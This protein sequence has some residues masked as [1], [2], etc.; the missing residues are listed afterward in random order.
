[1]KTL[2]KLFPAL[3]LLAALPANAGA[4]DY[5]PPAEPVV[6]PPT[7]APFSWTGPYIGVHA[8][9]AFLR[10]VTEYTKDIFETRTRDITEDQCWKWWRSAWNRQLDDRYC[11]G[12]FD[13][14]NQHYFDNALLR[15]GV[16]TGSEEYEFLVGTETWEETIDD[17]FAIYGVHAGYLHDFGTI[18]AGVE[19]SYTMYNSDVFPITGVAA[20]KGRAGLDLGRI[21]PYAFVGY[22]MAFGVE[23][24]GMVYGGGLDWAITDRLV[25]GAQYSHYDFRD[26]AHDAAVVIA[27]IRF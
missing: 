20:I 19:A 26:Y 7:T 14:M 21:Q 24:S 15:E 23:D 6:A 3:L 10:Q 18:V 9:A 17:S 25:L 1:M 27:S 5:E 22:G 13:G 8:G 11:S 12:G 16:V 4:L 2:M